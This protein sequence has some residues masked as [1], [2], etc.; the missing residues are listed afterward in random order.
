MDR[1]L[2]QHMHPFPLYHLPSCPY[3]ADT[4]SLRNENGSTRLSILYP[5]G[6]RFFFDAIR[7]KR[8]SDST[9]SMIRI[10]QEF[11]KL[12]KLERREASETRVLYSAN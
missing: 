9:H 10:L 5:H 6:R 4:H 2:L 1:A 11:Q 8:S 12:C 7:L 3:A